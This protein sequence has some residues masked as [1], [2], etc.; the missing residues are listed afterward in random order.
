M[1]SSP[2]SILLRLESNPKVFDILVCYTEKNRQ[3]TN[4]IDM[5]VRALHMPSIKQWVWSCMTPQ[6]VKFCY[7]SVGDTKGPS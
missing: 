4:A 7:S 3:C 1:K 5:E 2:I 6:Y